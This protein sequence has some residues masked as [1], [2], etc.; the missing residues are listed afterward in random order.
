MKAMAETPVAL[1]RSLLPKATDVSIV[2]EVKE[3]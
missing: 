3:P 2:S 1:V